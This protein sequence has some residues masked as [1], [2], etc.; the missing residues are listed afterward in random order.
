MN[1]LIVAFDGLDYNK[2]VELGLENITQSEFG[3]IDNSTG[4]NRILTPE[5]FASFI[6]GETHQAHG[7][8]K[9]SRQ[10]DPTLEKI[11]VFFEETLGTLKGSGIIK[12]IV[13]GATGRRE[14]KRPF[15]KHDLNIETIFE[16]VPDSR[17]VQIPSYDR[18][19]FLS[20]ANHFRKFGMEETLRFTDMEQDEREDELFTILEGNHNL[21]MAHFH[22]VDAY[23]DLYFKFLDKDDKNLDDLYY[24][25]DELA[26]EIIEEAT[27]YDCI[28]F[29]SDH[30]MPKSDEHNTNAFYSCNMRLYGNTE[31]HITDFHDKILEFTDSTA[32]DS[33][34]KDRKETPEISKQEEDEIVNRLEDM[35]YI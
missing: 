12:K 16:K 25:I 15:N 35:G 14:L 23:Q 9:F 3:T 30:G 21:V 32:K 31:P 6:T 4:I 33:T 10:A 5:L 18:I 17:T 7:V 27:E 26:S 34:G 8:K 11:D 24:E 22:I 28:I 2:I 20:F 1:V 29:M 13:S 19:L